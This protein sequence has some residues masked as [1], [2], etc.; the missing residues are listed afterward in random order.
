M[1][2]LVGIS[3][4]FLVSCSND[5]KK[6][7]EEYITDANNYDSASMK[8][9]LSKNFSI[10]NNPFNI[11]KAIDIDSFN[12][13]EGHISL[14]NISNKKGTIETTENWTSLYD[15]LLEIKP[16]VIFHNKYVIK[17]G[18]I[19]SINVESVENFSQ[20]KK[21][22]RNKVNAFDSYLKIEYSDLK[23]AKQNEQLINLLTTYSQLPNSTKK[24]YAIQAYLSDGEFVG[25][26]SFIPMK[27]K[28]KGKSTVFV[29]TM[30][31]N[32]GTTYTVDEDYIHVKPIDNS[33]PMTLSIQDDN[34]MSCPSIMGDIIF[35]RRKGK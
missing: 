28:F 8:K 13:I 3:A 6:V 1:Y 20:Y 19:N 27:L 23:E 2:V 32:M 26:Y 33:Y 21:E 10:I 22:Y 29:S 9:R 31:I 11:N 14:I 15:S 35:R 7:V 12:K 25:N 30:G 16:K 34:T 5:P 18:K 4:F 17:D 24:E